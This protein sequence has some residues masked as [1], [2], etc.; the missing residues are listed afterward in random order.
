MENQYF[1]PQ[2]VVSLYR[3]NMAFIEVT[4]IQL[5]APVAAA[6]PQGKFRE[7]TDIQ[8]DQPQEPSFLDQQR[9]RGAAMA[10]LDYAAQQGQITQPEAQVRKAGNFAGGVNQAVGGVV[11]AGYHAAM[12]DSGEQRVKKDLQRLAATPVGQAGIEALKTGGEI[13]GT[14]KQANPRTAG[15]IEAGANIAMAAPLVKPLVSGLT[16]AAKASVNAPEAIKA[17][18]GSIMKGA[19]KQLPENRKIL[20]PLVEAKAPLFGKPNRDLIG[21]SVNRGISQ[22]YGEAKKAVNNAYTAAQDTGNFDIPAPNIINKLDNLTTYLDEKLGKNTADR[23][24]FRTLDDIKEN[25]L[26]KN[27]VAVSVAGEKVAPRTISANDAIEM[28]KAINEALPQIG[29]AMKSGD[30]KLMDFKNHI[31]S[32]LDEAS[33]VNPDFGAN[34]QNAKQ[35]Y[36]EMADTYHSK[37]LNQ[38]WKPEDYKKTLNNPSKLPSEIASRASKTL[39]YLNTEDTGKIMAVLKA[40]PPEQGQD[41]INAALK[42]AKEDKV[43]LTNA[44]AQLI[45]QPLNPSVGLSIALRLAQ[46]GAGKAPLEKAINTTKGLRK[47][48]EEAK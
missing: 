4:D 25:I 11:E 5:D 10:N 30:V 7:V 20:Q 46:K 38:I 36:G 26:V 39:G 47:A 21:E 17:V 24:A 22:S 33:T 2:M 32:L 37:L 45:R 43:S 3:N 23:G 29:K 14:Y 12:T 15:I 13:W 31:N 42:L 35:L 19:E 16:S 6:M 41:V 9:Q 27:R 48:I 8:L 28:E 40:L 18:T 34:Y 44:A 1:K